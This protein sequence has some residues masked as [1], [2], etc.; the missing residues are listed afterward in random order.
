MGMW[1]ELLRTLDPAEAE[2]NG[3]KLRE[4]FKF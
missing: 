1:I 4:S 3:K 2:I